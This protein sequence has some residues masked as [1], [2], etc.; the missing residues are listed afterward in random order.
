MTKIGYISPNGV[1]TLCIYYDAKAKKNPYRVYLEW[2][3][4]SGPYDLRSRRKMVAQYA[5][6]YSCAFVL[7]G[8]CKE[9]NEEGR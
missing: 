9:H 8:W 5:D 7:L 3:E 4:V 1:H 2:K 6:L